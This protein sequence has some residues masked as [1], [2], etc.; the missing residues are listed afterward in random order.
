MSHDSIQFI[1]DILQN[2]ITLFKGERVHTGEKTRSK[3][4]EILKKKWIL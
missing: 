3:G 4:S 2:C 1:N